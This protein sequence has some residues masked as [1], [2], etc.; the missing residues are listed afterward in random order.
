VSRR[1]ASSGRRW[2]IAIA[3][4]ATIVAAALWWRSGGGEPASPPARVTA[5]FVDEQTCAACH[6]DE[7]AAWRQSHHS[8]AMQL[9]TDDT[10]LAD[11][12]D[13]TFTS[14]GLTSTFSRRNGA[15]VITTDGPDGELAD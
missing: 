4:V 1:V 9:P 5:T 11:F 12:N 3:A 8:L 10:V 6:S 7:E 2:V 14:F 13:T 15:F